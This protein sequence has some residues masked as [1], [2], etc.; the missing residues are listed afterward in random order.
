VEFD[1]RIV[2]AALAL[3]PPVTLDP[4]NVTCAVRVAG[5]RR[6]RWLQAPPEIISK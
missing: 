3:P 1:P 4:V 2:L 5:S 6:L